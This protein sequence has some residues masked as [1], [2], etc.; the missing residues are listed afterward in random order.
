M[1]K[2]L[3]QQSINMDTMTP[4]DLDQLS[5][6]ITH[7]LQAVDDAEGVKG[8]EVTVGEESEIKREP[9]AHGQ[10]GITSGEEFTPK[11][12]FHARL[13]RSDIFVFVNAVVVRVMVCQ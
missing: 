6:V 2:Q 13:F 4:S 7:A 9:W 5:E 3:G 8:R 12:A 11:G 10:L 1:V